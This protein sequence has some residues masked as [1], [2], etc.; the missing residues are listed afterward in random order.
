MAGWVSIHAKTGTF[1]AKLLK[2]LFFFYGI[3][4]YCQ[5][6][7]LLIAQVNYT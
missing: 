6:V 4:T 3:T 5:L 1:V 7:R 2:L